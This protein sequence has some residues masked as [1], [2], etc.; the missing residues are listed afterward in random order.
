MV[1]ED[2]ERRLRSLIA[3]RC[4][5]ENFDKPGSGYAFGQV[6]EEERALIEENIPGDPNSALIALSIADPTWKMPEEAVEAGMEY[7]RKCPDASRYTDNTGVRADNG[8][9]LGDTHKEICAFLERR[10]RN[11][12]SGFSPEWVQY[13]P[14]SIKRAL[15]EIIPTALFNKE[16]L[17]I[18][19]APGYPVISSSM[20]T[21][22]AGG[23][24][25][26]EV[27]MVPTKTREDW[28]IPLEKIFPTKSG[29]T[30]IYFNM[31]HNPTGS[32]Y[33]KKQLTQILE[34]AKQNRAFL[35]VD[36]AYNNLRY[37]NSTSILEIPGWEE[38]S[39]VLQ[40]VSKGW[41]ATGLRF[42]WIV[43]H[44]IMIKAIRKVMDVKDSGLFGPSIA[45]G[46]TCLRNYQ[47][48]EE[49][50]ENYRNL[51]RILAQGLKKAGFEGKMPSAGLCQFTPAPRST[52]GYEFKSL[53]ECVQWFRKTLR[54]SLMHYEVGS[55]WY[56][57]WAVTV[58]PVPECGL[59]DEASVIEEVVRRL[60]R[61]EFEF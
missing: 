32:T 31:P 19:P 60:Q 28:Q 37:D 7:F 12:P 58:K 54:V 18:F 41:S 56:L 24:E 1:E 15:A 48:A 6:L 25:V 42:G 8:T 49:T 61:V 51:H 55:Q 39:V 14:G 50:R 47:W 36:E 16:D 2:I 22:G 40:S 35:I 53:V 20:N 46:L 5:G 30:Y 45:A 9:E 21:Y 4:G 33:D 26:R 52:D 34:W 57:R 13:S 38:C 17:L 43:G 3:N 23:I 29:N 10:I 27:E 44:P 11:L 59:P